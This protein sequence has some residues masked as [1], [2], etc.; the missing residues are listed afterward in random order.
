VYVG[1]NML[2]GTFRR[3]NEGDCRCPEEVVRRMVAE[4]VED[5]RD[6]RVLVHYGMSDLD[7]KTIADYRRR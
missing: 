4:Q 1:Q 5:S 6:A 3:N 2:T 7:S